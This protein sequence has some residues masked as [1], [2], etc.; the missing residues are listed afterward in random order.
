MVNENKTEK[1]WEIIFI[2][3]Y[4]WEL[5]TICHYLWCMKEYCFNY[6]FH[7]IC[8]LS[9]FFFCN[10]VE[11]DTSAKIG[12]SSWNW[13]RNCKMSLW[14]IRQLNSSICTKRQ[15]WRFSCIGDYYIYGKLY[16]KIQFTLHIANCLYSILEQMLNLQKLIQLSFGLIYIIWQQ[17]ERNIILKE[18]WN[19]IQNG[20]IVSYD[21]VY[22]FSSLKL[23]LFYLCL[24]Y[25][26]SHITKYI[27]LGNWIESFISSWNC[28]FVCVS[29][30]VSYLKAFLFF[31]FIISFHNNHK[32][33]NNSNTMNS[34]FFCCCCL[35]PKSNEK[36]NKYIF[37]MRFILSLP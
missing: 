29:M 23:L 6:L 28:V 12:A 21:T 22:D 10:K 4:I 15:S 36:F 37:E 24:F 27:L 32:T 20:L 31:L 25:I 14:S 1:V 5:E 3:W 33:H 16:G 2:Y 18:L 19:M 17:E 30:F 9:L 35:L 13:F 8:F 34:P 26:E 11:S 7:F